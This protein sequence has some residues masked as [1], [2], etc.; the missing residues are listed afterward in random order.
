MLSTW[1][2]GGLQRLSRFA[3]RVSVDGDELEDERLRK[4]LTVSVPIIQGPAVIPWILIYLAVGE[5]QA[6]SIPILY[7]VL[8]ALNI[9]ALYMTRWFAGFRIAQLSLPLFLP[10]L[11]MI[12]LGG[13]VNSSA[14]TI[15]SII[16]PLSA[17]VFTS[18]REA[19]LWFVAFAGL[20]V[21]GVFL[22]PVFRA[23]NGISPT[24]RTLFFG[25]NLIVPAVISFVLLA[26]FVGQLR[27]E[28]ARSESLL[29]NILPAEIA[30]LLKDGDRVIADRYE[31]VSVLFADIVGSTAL[32]A[33]LPPE[34]LVELL[35]E[36]FSHF[37][38]L[39]E[40]HGLEKISTIG[41]GYVVAGGLPRPRTDHARAIAALALDMRAYVNAASRN[42][43]H[44][45]ECR[46]GINSGP[47]VAGVIGKKKF[48]YDIWGDAVNT[49]S[50]MESH[51]EP[52]K[53]QI[54]Q[55][56]YDLTKDD[57]IC[58]PRGTI[59]VKGLGEVE[60][61]FLESAKS[62]VRAI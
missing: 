17:L 61:W 42:G 3:E 35:N 45:V 5:T 38:D 44:G 39:T 14:I 57:F 31:S 18:R 36:L 54:S 4:I 6:A 48:R 25:M 29:L 50:R 10:F 1:T 56:T 62:G 8:T 12:A 21:L 51:G 15:W 34:E 20:F 53:I 22:E 30:A 37:D 16:T 47:V 23:E 24:L 60:T 32:A 58:E 2:H 11:M 13:F 41:D 59:E 7:W 55:A 28:Q 49:A 26:Y 40:K 46:I 33:K 43:A 19:T 27:R 52:G 9:G